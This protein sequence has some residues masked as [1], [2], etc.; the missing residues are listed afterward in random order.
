MKSTSFAVSS[1]T[2]Q[3]LLDHHIISGVIKNDDYLVCVF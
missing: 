3:F 1:G 2:Y